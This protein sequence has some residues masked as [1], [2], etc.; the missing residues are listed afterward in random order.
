MVARP[1]DLEANHPLLPRREVIAEHDKVKFDYDKTCHDRAYEQWYALVKGRPV[2]QEVTQIY[3]RKIPAEGE[4]LTYNVHFLGKDWKGNDQDFDTLMG[5]YEKPVFRL[6]KDPSTQE[7]TSTQISSHRTVYDVPFSKNK[8]DDL[9][10]MS[11]EP[12]S[13]IVY[14]SAGRKYGLQSVDD[15]REGAIEDLIMCG[16]KGKTLESVLA[17]KNQYTYEKRETKRT[18]DKLDRADK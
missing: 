5:R 13:L 2:T 7:V 11:A 8:L 1:F 14:G 4:F 10:D 17:E 3:R 18:S 15:F 16:N 9:L 6:D 12:L